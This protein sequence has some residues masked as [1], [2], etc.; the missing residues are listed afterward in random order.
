MDILIQLLVWLFRALFGEV[1]KPPEE[2]GGQFPVPPQRPARRGPYAYG[3]EQAVQGKTL[4]QILEDV[5]KSAAQ[6]KSETAAPQPPKTV[7]EYGFAAGKPK[8]RPD[9]VRVRPRPKPAPAVAEPP[10][11]LVSLKVEVPSLK[12][13]ITAVPAGLEQAPVTAAPAGPE[14]V[15]PISAVPEVVP[16]AEAAAELAKS[17]AARAGG[18]APG[19]AGLLNALL[20]APPEQ[21]SDAARQAIV[22]QEIFG[23]PRCRRPHRAGFARGEG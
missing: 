5:R 23:P 14:P 7:K 1:D 18:L 21:K 17:A 10:E 16:P 2:R 3:D 4:E 9:F 12:E 13:A 19:I 8:I 22:L 20:Q 6:K 11:Q 15:A